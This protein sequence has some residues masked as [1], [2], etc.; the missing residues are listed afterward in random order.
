MA[1]CL[2]SMCRE[3]PEFHFS[4]GFGVELEALSLKK[5]CRYISYKL[6]ISNIFMIDFQASMVY[7]CWVREGA[8]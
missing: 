5:M 2:P 3:G 1:E 7:H 8:S 6:S 4:A